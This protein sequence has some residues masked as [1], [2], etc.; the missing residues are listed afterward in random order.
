VDNIE[1]IT[2]QLQHHLQRSDRG[3]KRTQQQFEEVNK[4]L[5]DIAYTTNSD[6][7]D[8]FDVIFEIMDVLNLA[9]RRPHATNQHLLNKRVL[10]LIQKH[11]KLYP[12]RLTY[13]TLSTYD[14]I[15][16]WR[17]FVQTELIPMWETVSAQ[18]G[19]LAN[20]QP[21]DNLAL[22]AITT[23]TNDETGDGKNIGEKTS[24]ILQQVDSGAT[25]AK[26]VKDT[27]E[28]LTKTNILRCKTRISEIGEA[29]NK[30][31]MVHSWARRSEDKK[32]NDSEESLDKHVETLQTVCQTFKKVRDAELVGVQDN[33]KQVLNVLYNYLIYLQTPQQDLTKNLNH[34]SSWNLC[35][36]LWVQASC[37]PW[38]LMTTVLDQNRTGEAS[39]SRLRDWTSLVENA[40]WQQTEEVSANQWRNKRWP[41]TMWSFP[42]RFD[43]PGGCRLNVIVDY[44][45][46]DE[47][48]RVNITE[49]DTF[50]KLR[51]TYVEANGEVGAH[52]K[53]YTKYE[54]GEFI[55]TRVTLEPFQVRRDQEEMETFEFIPSDEYI[56]QYGTAPSFAGNFLHTENAGNYEIPSC[57]PKNASIADWPKHMMLSNNM[58]V[59]YLIEKGFMDKKHSKKWR[60]DDEHY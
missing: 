18:I 27:V 28:Y 10:R 8:E 7:I 15:E 31:K 41:K 45:T 38:S 6:F 48:W 40:C 57:I 49:E 39:C 60:Y 59:Q 51:D 55:R 26:L 19:K 52:I 17:T 4:Q 44:E 46:I 32:L 11:I 53:I 47:G 37:V 34:K 35:H 54:N 21:E 3:E 43:V 2:T 5:E 16:Q 30:L 14:H 56:K 13:V 50:W 58:I 42:S 9:N 1:R 23:A 36:Y 25:E 33:L 29:L 24:K 20:V 22:H 12:T